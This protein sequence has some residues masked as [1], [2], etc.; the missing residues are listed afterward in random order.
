MRVEMGY[1]PHTDKGL[2]TDTSKATFARLGKLPSLPEL[3]IRALQDLN[4]NQNI[5]V[6]SDKIGQDPP[7]VARILRIANS[8][9]YGMT[10]EIGSLR[11]AILL[12]G[13]NR[14]RDILVGICFSKLLPVRH[15][16]FDYTLFWHHS[17]A[18]ADCTR[19]LANYA[20][21]NQEIA[22]TAGLLHDIGRLIIVVLFPDVFSH[23]SDESDQPLAVMERRILGFDHMEIGGQVAS[24]WNFPDAI[25]EAIELHEIP[26]ARNS[27]KSL[28]LLVY[29]ANL[30]V[31][32]T[33]PA[34]ES[35][36]AEQEA[37]RIA[38]DIL[39]LPIDQM[40]LFVRTARQFADHIVSIL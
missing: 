33:I 36:L 34:N 4:N 16:H 37:C 28:P 15:Q 3:L 23:I 1:L 17:L 21:I 7:L 30:L 29:V 24:H 9:F 11:E 18:V 32:E 8:S 13:I 6:L 12:L 35:P 19:Q 22:F 40:V 39:E 25:R 20:G 38:L 26:P 14:V 2:T 31:A 5:A 10:R 27:A